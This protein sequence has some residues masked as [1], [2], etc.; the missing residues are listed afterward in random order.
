MWPTTAPFDSIFSFK[1]WPLVHV[2]LIRRANS[3]TNLSG[4]GISACLD[5]NH[6]RSI[7]ITNFSQKFCINFHENLRAA[8]CVKS[9]LVLSFIFIFLYTC[10]LAL[11]PPPPPTP[12]AS[13]LPLLLFEIYDTINFVKHL[14]LQSSR[15]P[16]RS[17]LSLPP[18]PSRHSLSLSGS[19]NTRCLVPNLM[20]NALSMPAL[21][22]FPP[23]FCFSLFDKPLVKMTNV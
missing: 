6:L 4:Q 21:F 8:S 18:F 2:L 14:K 13:L 9:F 3:R 22:R 12:P 1:H 23:D 11:K 10:R 17:L 19:S 5:E 15:N 16:Q 20:R 7:S